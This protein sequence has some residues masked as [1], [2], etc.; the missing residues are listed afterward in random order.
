MQITLGIQW[1]KD[2][3]A[4]EQVEFDPELHMFLTGHFNRTRIK[5]SLLHNVTSN[6]TVWGTRSADMGDIPA[7]AAIV[8]M[9][10]AKHRNDSGVPC[11]VDAGTSHIMLKE[12][13]NHNWNRD[14]P[15]VKQAHLLMHT[16]GNFDKGTI[17][18]T[19]HRAQDVQLA[20][21]K[22]AAMHIDGETAGR[23]MIRYIQQVMD[24]EQRMGDTLDGTSNIRC[25]IDA[26]QAGW[27][28]TGVPTPA[29]GYVLNPERPKSNGMFW[30]NAYERVMARDDLNPHKWDTM[31]I[32]ERARITIKMVVYPVQYMPYIG[33]KIDRNRRKQ[34]Y[35]V[36]LKQGIE[37]F[38]DALVMWSGDCEDLAKVHCFSFCFI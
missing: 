1:T 31:T 32:V 23:S 17:T 14:G 33:D 37:D 8:F 15:F 6:H 5:T 18:V 34:T 36:Q 19:V 22:I 13:T 27:Q 12:L 11:M 28:L 25:P 4:P 20:D 10:I 16:A 35:R 2:G 29:Q 3:L 7:T 38:G 26:S 9:G 24:K 21:L 30:S